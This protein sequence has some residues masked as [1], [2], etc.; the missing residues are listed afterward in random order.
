M[1]PAVAVTWAH[2]VTVVLFP[3]AQAVYHAHPRRA[4]AV[5]TAAPPAALAAVAVAIAAHAVAARTAA[6]AHA[7]AAAP[8]A[9]VAVAAAVAAVAAAP[10]DQVAVVV[11]NPSRETSVNLCQ[12]YTLL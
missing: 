9:A 3:A 6:V 5:A 2:A 7:A 4:A 12:C 10:E 1:Q 8:T 11:T